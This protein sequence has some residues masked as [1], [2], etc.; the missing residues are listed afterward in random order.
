MGKSVLTMTEA[1]LYCAEGD[2]FIDPWRP[3]PRAVVTHAHSDHARWGMERYLCSREGEGVLRLRVGEDAAID[4]LEF[5]ETVTLGSAKLSLHPAGHILGSAQVRV[6]VNGEV[7]AVSGDYKTEPDR[8]CTA[9]EPIRCH[10]FVTES[11]FGLP[12]YRWEPE[13]VVQAQINDW[14]RENQASGKCSI[15]VGYALGKSQRALAGL[16]PELGPIFLHGA[17]RKLTEAYREAGVALPPTH[18]VGEVGKGFDWSRA[19]VIAPP[20]ALGTSWLK[21][22]GDL[23]TGYM[24][25]WMA[26]RGNRRRRAV[27]RGFVLSDHVDWP[28]L[29]SAVEATGAENIWVTHGYSDVVSRYL[30]ERGLK[31]MPLETVWEGERADLSISAEEEG[32]E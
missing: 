31:S 4:T 14:W 20:S 1:G 19:L 17:V 32:E 22:F 7:V 26:I 9:F 25:G 3:V 2:F 29:L 21:R 28:S 6:E 27:D 30:N 12:I 18:V 24:S 5:G 10:T 13:G 15:L 23:S 16:D 8:T 11:T